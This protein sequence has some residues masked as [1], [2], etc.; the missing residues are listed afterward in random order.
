[1][2]VEPIPSDPAFPMMVLNLLRNVLSHAADPGDLGN[3][4]TEELLNITGARCILFIQ[5]LQT[6]TELTHRVVS[7]RPMR[8]YRWA[9]SEEMKRLY[10]IACAQPTFQVWRVEAESETMG[11]LLDRGYRLSAAFPLLI[12]EERVGSMLLLGLPDTANVAPLLDLLNSLS[13]IVALVLRNSFLY[14]KQERII[15]ERT[16]ELRRTNER[17]QVELTER[18]LVEARLREQEAH[19]CEA[20]KIA[21]MGSWTHDLKTDEIL[22]SEGSRRIFDW[23]KEGPIS[24]ETFL[25]C[26]YPE[27][28]VRLCEALDQARNGSESVLIVE[29]RIIR[30]DGE[31]RPLFVRCHVIRDSEGQAV[32]V[33]GIQLDLTERKRAEEALRRSE[34]RFRLIAENAHDVIYRMSLPDGGYEY[35]S[36]A[37][38]RI[39][40]YSPEECYQNPRLVQAMIH[41]DW[42][43]YFLEEWEKLLRGEGSESYEYQIRHRSGELRWL[44]QRNVLICDEMGRPVAIEG[45]VSDIT[46]RKQK[47]IELEAR[48][49]LLEAE[50]AQRGFAGP[51]KPGR[52]RKTSGGGS[53]G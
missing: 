15:H 34:E 43:A 46:E 29:Y 53:G 14:E 13:S 16:G 52:R 21:Q 41:P 1:M 17:L 2:S 32:R 45:L 11:I 48:I 35:V 42:Q 20:Q 30:P 27:D 7:V 50:L 22:W 38:E 5:N 28:L 8:L 44:Y 6:E 36:P 19:L 39:T 49:R 33:E 10:R 37:V 4:L 31:I 23:P 18:R 40:G 26:V 51:D 24:R 47:E 3:Y 12:G 9:E 25:R